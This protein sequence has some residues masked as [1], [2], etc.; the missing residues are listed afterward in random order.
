MVS[1]DSAGGGGGG[2][3]AFE[4]DFGYQPR[5]IGLWCYRGMNG[6]NY[7]LR[8]VT[9]DT[10]YNSARALGV[11][12]SCLGFIGWLFYLVATCFPFKP[13]IFRGV[14]CL[15]IINC[16]FQ[17]LVFLLYRS[18]V[19]AGGC[20]LDTSGKCAISACVFYFVGGVASCAAGKRVEEP[21]EDREVQHAEDDEPVKNADLEEQAQPVVANKSESECEA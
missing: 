4:F 2:G 13:M 9:F 16:M 8:D 6:E 14:G 11:T 18:D 3:G 12:A 21:A 15:M 1:L 17:G 7:D 10:M 20:S 19:C 5:A